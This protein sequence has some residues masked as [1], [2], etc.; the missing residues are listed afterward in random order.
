ML[1]T[2]CKKVN[3]VFGRFMQYEAN[4]KHFF[5]PFTLYSQGN[6][7]SDIKPRCPRINKMR[8]TADV[9]G[10]KPL[11]VLSQTVSSVI[12]FQN[13]TKYGKNHR[14]SICRPTKRG[15]EKSPSDGHCACEKEM[16]DHLLGCQQ[17]FEK[18]RHGDTH[19]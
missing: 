13:R 4:T 2:R 12:G 1:A 3:F 19:C 5:I 14:L 16:D 8:N 15:K 9:T 6:A 11:T 17:F 7:E 10:G 18:V